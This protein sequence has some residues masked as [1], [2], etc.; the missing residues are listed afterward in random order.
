MESQFPFIPFTWAK[1]CSVFQVDI[2]RG[3]LGFQ[4]N[5]CEI[6]LSNVDK[7]RRICNRVDIRC[8][9]FVDTFEEFKKVVDSCF[10]VNLKA[11]YINNFDSF[12][13]SF[14]DLDIFITSKVHTTIFHVK[15]FCQIY[16]LGLGYFSEQAFE[17]LHHD[18][19]KTWGNF[20]VHSTNVHYGDELPRSVCV[21]NGR[22]L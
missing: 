15:E 5:S 4:G 19:N 20:K 11:D 7:L 16:G 18:F 6:L 13:K 8:L 17:S 10:S 3:T 12:E 22:H 2:Y 14:K 9:N 1:E 21:Y